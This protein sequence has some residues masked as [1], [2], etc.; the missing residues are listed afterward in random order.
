MPKKKLIMWLCDVEFLECPYCCMTYLS[1][2]RSPNR[3]HDKKLKS[4]IKLLT[5]YH[6]ICVTSL[7]SLLQ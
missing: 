5:H 4:F 6:N 1:K 2:D 7:M 3:I